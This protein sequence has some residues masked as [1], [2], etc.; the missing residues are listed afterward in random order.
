MSTLHYTR[1][2]KFCVCTMVE[3]LGMD[4]EVKRTI[5]VIE[6]DPNQQVIYKISMQKAGYSTII[7]DNALDGLRWLEQIL[8]DMILMDMNLPGISGLE[9]LQR[10]RQTENGRDVPVIVATA[11]QSFHEEDFMPY[12]VAQFMRKPIRPSIL[13]D[14]INRYFEDHSV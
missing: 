11:S 7:R 5:L 4:D 6:D 2:N 12:Q 9:M 10:I 14:I 13:I 8:P 3:D 1:L